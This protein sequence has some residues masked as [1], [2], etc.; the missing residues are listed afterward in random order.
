M[1]S[2]LYCKVICMNLCMNLLNLNM[3]HLDSEGKKA[4]PCKLCACN[5]LNEGLRKNSNSK[6]KIQNA[7]EN[8]YS[9]TNM[10]TVELRMI[11]CGR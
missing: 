1:F 2:S 8:A 5:S 9:K 6:R 11:G 3:E 4:T 10:A 7:G